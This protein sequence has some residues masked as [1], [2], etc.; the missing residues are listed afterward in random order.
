MQCLFAA[1]SSTKRVL[2]SVL[3]PF[4]KPR[5]VDQPSLFWKSSGD[6]IK[7][8]SQMKV[9][10]P[11]FD[12]D[13]DT[14]YSVKWY[15]NEQEFFRYVPNDRPKLQIFPQQGIRVEVKNTQT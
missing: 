4:S 8:L 15:R 6:Q 2:I 10:V 13:G 12:M 11:R 14:L 7:L 3:E 1:F 5:L 9:F